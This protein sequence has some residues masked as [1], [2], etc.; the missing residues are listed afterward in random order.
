M[1]F[2][3]DEKKFNRSVGEETITVNGTSTTEDIKKFRKQIWSEEKGFK[4]GSQWIKHTPETNSNKQQQNLRKVSKEE[5]QAALKNFHKQKSPG[6]DKI[7]KFCL[8]ALSKGHSKVTTLLSDTVEIPEKGLKWRSEGVTYL[9]LKTADARNPKNYRPITCLR[10][11][12]KILT[13][14]LTERKCTFMEAH[15]MEM[16][17]TRLT[18]LQRSTSNKQ[19]ENRT[20]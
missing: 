10:T 8:D 5:L 9:L 16:M 13:S 2:K 19:N 4:K 6:I 7:L 15:E 14:V 3:T 1:I 12:Y 18:Q 11:T 20:S 17:E